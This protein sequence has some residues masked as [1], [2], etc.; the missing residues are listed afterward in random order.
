MHLYI[1]IRSEKN[2]LL[3]K[4][5]YFTSSMENTSNPLFS[6]SQ[7]ELPIKQSHLHRLELFGVSRIFSSWRISS[8][9]LTHLH[10]LGSTELDDEEYRLFGA[11]GLLFKLRWRLTQWHSVWLMKDNDSI[12]CSF[13]PRTETYIYKRKEKRIFNVWLVIE[14]RLNVDGKFYLFIYFIEL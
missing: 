1:K 8:N 13:F 5:T 2:N 12:V 6:K 14:L 10:L 7:S 4:K 11:G 3:K 9:C